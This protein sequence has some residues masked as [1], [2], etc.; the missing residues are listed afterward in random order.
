MA[1]TSILAKNMV[2]V[3]G[4]TRAGKFWLASLLVHFE[5][6]E[7]VQYRAVMDLCVSM[8]LL[9][10]ISENAAV[11][12]LQNEANTHIYETS[13]GRNL[14]FK[15][16]DSSSVCK[17]PNFQI[18]QQRVAA[19]DAPPHDMAG[20]IRRSDQQFL[21]IAHNWLCNAPLCF[22]A[23]PDVRLIRMERNPI[24]LVYA[25]HAK[26]HGQPRAFAGRIVGKSGPQPW[27]AADWSEEYEGLGEM[28]RIIRSISHLDG[29]AKRSLKAL[30]EPLR[31]RI[32]FTSYEALGSRPVAEA[33]RI[34]DSLGTRPGSTLGLFVTQESLKK[35]DQGSLE[36]ARADKLA[37]IRQAATPRYVEMLV[38]LDR[39]YAAAQAA[40]RA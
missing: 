11:S 26:G 1:E 9:D 6:M 20:E 30:P 24:D 23:F 12:L 22:K 18:Y 33:E 28:D 13:I 3:D 27:F 40:A 39:S 19:P 8:N 17:N 5:K 34:A 21:F 35:R 32:L 10:V 29:T 16:A 4:I 7:H 2:V 31:R 38:E 25:W 14:N 36:K 37:R 15:V